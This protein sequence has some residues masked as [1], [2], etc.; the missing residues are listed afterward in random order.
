MKN[1][2]ILTLTLLILFTMTTVI[3]TTQVQAFD[4]DPGGGNGIVVNTTFKAYVRDVQSS[5][6]MQGVSVKLKLGGTVLQTGTTNSLG[7]YYF[8]TV[9]DGGSTD[10]HIIVQ[11]AKTDPG[12]IDRKVTTSSVAGTYLTTV[13]FDLNIVNKWAVLVGLGDWSDSR[14]GDTTGY[15]DANDWYSRLTA[16]GFNHITTLGDDTNSYTDPNKILATKSNIKA[17]VNHVVDEADS[18]DIVVFTFATHCGVAGMACWD[19]NKYNV[20]TYLWASWFGPKVDSCKSNRIFT[21]IHSCSAG[22]FI[23]NA[24]QN[25]DGMIYFGSGELWMGSSTGSQKSFNDNFRRD[26]WQH[27]DLL[28]GLGTVSLESIFTSLSTEYPKTSGD[29]TM[30]PCMYDTSTQ[31][32]YLYN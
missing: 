31:P 5:T 25:I 12:Y 11:S 30:E 27:T 32:F 3:I 16:L 26:F 13:Q 2:K 23:L 9:T 20:F 21:W 14:L 15:L 17:A 24:Q 19:T 28:G 6:P 8:N 22:N 29:M 7:H 4:F 10:Y 18:N 1:K